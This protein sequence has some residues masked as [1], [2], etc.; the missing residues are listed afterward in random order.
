MIKSPVVE[1]LAVDKL[2]PW[3]KNP[4]KGHAVDVIAESIKRFGYLVPIVAQKGTLRVLAGHGRLEALKKAG[5]DR[6]PVIIAD[7]DD[8]QADLFTITDNKTTLL[9]EWDFQS[10]AETLKKA[11]A[12]LDLA[13]L[14]WGAHELE[15]ILNANW[16]TKAEGDLADFQRK[17]E[18][19]P[20]RCSKPERQAID[21][22]VAIARERLK[23]P[24]A[25]EGAILAAICRAWSK[26]QK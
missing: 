4:R 8:K 9:A 6:V 3:D 5:I 15:P 24:D 26:G 1:V 7:L 17:K 20:I 16:L 21:K 18:G 19:S 12:E 2:Q 22:A 23:M 10:L 14:G 25:T 13:P 11:S